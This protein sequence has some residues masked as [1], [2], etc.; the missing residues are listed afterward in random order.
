MDNQFH[1]T[2]DRMRRIAGALLGSELARAC[3]GLDS[4]LKKINEEL[5]KAGLAGKEGEIAVS[6][7]PA[8]GCA[9]LLAMAMMTQ[10]LNS[11]HAAMGDNPA[12]TP[13]TVTPSIP[14]LPAIELEDP[15][16]AQLKEEFAKMPKDW[17]IN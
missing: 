12:E 14:D 9:V 4:L 11:I 2:G 13:D 1:D 10:V 17:S 3:G 16:T 7:N 6:I 5:D 8:E 15:V